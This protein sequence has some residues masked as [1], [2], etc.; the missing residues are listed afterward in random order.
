MGGII[1]KLISENIRM[2]TSIAATRRRNIILDQ[3]NTTSWCHSKANSTQIKPFNDMYL[4][5]VVVVP[6]DDEYKKRLMV[7]KTEANTHN[8]RYLSSENQIR[9]MK[10]RFALPADGGE[11]PFKEINFTELNREEA[12]KLVQQ[13]NEETNKN[14]YRRRPNRSKVTKIPL[15]PKMQNT[16]KGSSI[17]QLLS[18][19]EK[20]SLSKESLM[21]QANLIQN[22]VIKNGW[23]GSP[24]R[25]AQSIVGNDQSGAISSQ[26]GISQG[27]FNGVM[28]PFQAP[29]F[30]GGSLNQM[31]GGGYMGMGM[32]ARRF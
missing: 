25:G 28:N 13:Y 24:M 5:A 2:W 27:M 9:S 1:V 20:N 10:A 3:V 8:D 32:N 18:T 21:H 30:W 7:Q 31:F 14:N 6:S 4:R 22:A 16:R 17:S 26:T 15:P 12:S 11:S 19:Q 29:S 23:M